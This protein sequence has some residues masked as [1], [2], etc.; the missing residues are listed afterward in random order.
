MKKARQS[1]TGT[2]VASPPSCRAKTSRNNRTS[3]FS[4]P[5]DEPAMGVN[6]ARE[7]FISAIATGGEWLTK[8]QTTSAGLYFPLSSKVSA[9][10]RAGR[11]L[12]ETPS[13]IVSLSNGFHE[14]Y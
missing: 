1:G 11:G 5:F 8:T 7:D 13:E 6:A 10:P 12:P 3:L 2:R 9:A 14:C 4:S